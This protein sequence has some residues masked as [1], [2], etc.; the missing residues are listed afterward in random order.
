MKPNIIKILFGGFSGTLMMSLMMQFAA[1]MMVG[2][3]MDIAAM[4]GN[5]M[6]GF[7]GTLGL[8]RPAWDD[9]RGINMH[10]LQRGTTPGLIKQ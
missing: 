3:P 1:P 5:K 9:C 6:G 4:L 7:D 10:Q 2:Q 8:R